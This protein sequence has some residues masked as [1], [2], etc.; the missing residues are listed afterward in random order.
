MNLPEALAHHVLHPAPGVGL[1]VVAMLGVFQQNGHASHVCGGAVRDTLAGQPFNDVDFVVEADFATIREIVHA[2]FGVCCERSSNRNFGLLKI[3]RDAG[4]EIDITM[5]R[6]PDDVGDAQRLEDVVYAPRTSLR[7]D[8]RN[9]DLTI[10][11]VYWNALEGFVDPLGRG[12]ED[13][14]S[15]RFEVA[16]DPRKSRI[17]PRLSVRI[18][19]FAARGYAMG[20]SATEYLLGNL[21]RDLLRYEALDQYVALVVRGSRILAQELRVVGHA[22]LRDAAARA[23]IDRACDNV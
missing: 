1:D 22:Y 9:R 18:L 15:R 19:L 13:I 17:D 5:L 8:A 21:D 14:A 3:G 4:S 12:I 11:C 6:S 2:E 16:A 23:A 7:D 20:E 10:N